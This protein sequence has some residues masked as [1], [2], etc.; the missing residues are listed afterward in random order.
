MLL[1]IGHD[2]TTVR[3]MPWV[4][5]TIIGLCLLVFTLTAIAPSGEENIAAC[6]RRAVEFYLDHPHLA[7]DPALKGYT[8]YSLRQQRSEET[9]SPPVSADDLRREQLELDGLVT[10]FFEARDNTPCSRWGLIPARPRPVTWLTHML[11]HAGALHLFAN[12]F[13]LYLVGPPLEDAWGHPLF[14]VFYVAAGLLAAL[15]F[16]ARFPA[17]DEPLIGASGAISGVMGAF[18]VRY[19]NSRI[20]FAYWL[21]LIK[22]YTGTF[23]APAWLM[24][25]LWALMQVAFASG[26]WAFTS[27]ADM[28]NVAFGAHVAGFVF[29]VGV[30]VLVK[31]LDIEERFIDPPI[32]RGTVV[33]D[34][35]SVEAALDLAQRGRADEAVLLLERDLERNPRDADAASALWTIAV[36]AGMGARVAQRMGVPLEA[37]ARAGDDGLPALCWGELLRTAPEIDVATSTAVRLG[38]IV[39]AAGLS[40]DAEE[41][42]RW[43]EGRVGGTTPVGLLVRLAR[44]ADHL[45]VRAPFAELALVRGELPPEIEEELR[46]LFSR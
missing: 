17:I 20:T 43:L 4:T 15:F 11:M 40:S 10:A 42:L 3:R 19:G 37:A 5:L 25:G 24:L 7:L 46:T 39:L 44:M 13:I 35:R 31:K 29:G 14:A 12:L 38:E 22:I 2:Q 23:E 21:F 36:A 45:G 9:P 26:M 34:A 16:V 1:P 30:A 28:G 32:E 27:I 18:A 6:E 8:Y 41:T 33:H